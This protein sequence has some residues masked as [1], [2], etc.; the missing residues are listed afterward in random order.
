MKKD[1]TVLEIATAAALV[2]I[3]VSMLK[4]GAV[5]SELRIKDNKEARQLCYEH[6]KTPVY[7]GNGRI[8]CP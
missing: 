3:V 2:W 5:E 4:C 6:G 1:L 8:V 7:D